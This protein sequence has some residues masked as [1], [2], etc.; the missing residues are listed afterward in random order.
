MIAETVRGTHTTP[1]IYGSGAYVLQLAAARN[2]AAGRPRPGLDVPAADE[3]LGY[4]PSSVPTV[5][6]SNCSVDDRLNYTLAL[7]V[8]PPM[9]AEAE[10]AEQ[11]QTR[12]L[13]SD[14]YTPLEVGC[15]WGPGDE[16]GAIF[17]LPVK[18]LIGLSRPLEP[19]ADA[20][21]P[22]RDTRGMKETTGG[23]M[24]PPGGGIPRRT[25]GFHPDGGVYLHAPLLMMPPSSLAGRDTGLFLRLH[26]KLEEAA[27]PAAR[28]VRSV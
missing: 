20:V 28:P 24:D 15:G 12:T 4:V 1:K 11:K 10:T 7:R 14:Q 2:V 19:F 25:H 5:T 21:S 16:A 3:E 13:Q 23:E 8:W 18:E 27:E 9:T 26:V 17:S 22:Q 6:V